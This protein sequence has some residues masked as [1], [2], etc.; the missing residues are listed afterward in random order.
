MVK[1][2]LAV[3]T[4]ID[5]SDVKLAFHARQHSWTEVRSAGE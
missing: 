5:N 2:A 1:E 4:A 3:S